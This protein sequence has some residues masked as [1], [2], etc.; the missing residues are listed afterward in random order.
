M[1]T[2]LLMSF[3]E[4][5]AEKRGIAPATLCGLAA[6]NNRIYRNLKSGGTCTLEVTER[7]C[8]WVRLHPAQ[9]KTEDA[10]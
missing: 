6:G 8:L 5:E 4:V 9:V 7:I 10:A 3:I 1:L 2:D